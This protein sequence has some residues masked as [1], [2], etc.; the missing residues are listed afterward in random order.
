MRVEPYLDF[1]GRCEEAIEFYKKSLGAEVT[2]LMRF[3]NAPPPPPGANC[4]PPGDANKI[5]HSSLR[6]GDSTVMATDGQSQGAT[7]F[8]GTALSLTVKTDEQAKRAFTALADGGKICVPLGKTFFSSN[9]GMV[10]DRFGVPWM[11]V[12]MQ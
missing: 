1:G 6:I 8:S 5:M 9:F 4:P 11:V 3:Q 10:A 7:K 2:M 12:V